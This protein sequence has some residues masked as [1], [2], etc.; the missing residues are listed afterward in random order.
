MQE[1]GP[2]PRLEGAQRDLLVLR[3]QRRR[4][5]MQVAGPVSSTFTDP[6]YTPSDPGSLGLAGLATAS[7]LLFVP[8]VRQDRQVSRRVMPIVAGDGRSDVVLGV[9]GAF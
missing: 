9:G 3:T 8:P 6:S 4:A 1:P 2:S 5:V 7:V